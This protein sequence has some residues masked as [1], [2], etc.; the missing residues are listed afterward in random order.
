MDRSRTIFVAKCAAVLGVIPVLAWAYSTGPLPHNTGAPGDTT[1]SQSG[2]HAFTNKS[3]VNTAGGSVQFTFSS[4]TTYTPGTNVHVTV[5][6]TDSTRV[7]GF[8][9]SARIAGSNKQAGTFVKPATGVKQFVQCE[10]TNERDRSSTQGVCPA[11]AP[12]EFIQHSTP[13]TVGKFE[14]D[15]TPPAASIGSVML[16]VAANAANGNGDADAGD[17]IYTTSAT[18]TPATTTGP[19]PTI[20]AGGIAD[21]FN[22]T[23]GVAPETWISIYGTNLASATKTWDGDPAFA[24]GHLPT[25]VSGVSVTVNGKAAPVYFVSSGQINI[26]SP[27]DSATGTVAV[28]VTNANGVSD[29][30]MVTKSNALPAFYAPFN[31]NGKLYVT[32]VNPVSNPAEYWGKVGLDPRVSRPVK[33]GETIELF[34]TGWGSSTNSSIT[35]DM[36]TFTAAPLV[37]QPTITIGG[38][39]AQLSGGAGYLVSPGLYQFNVIV[40]NVPDGDQP[41]SATLGSVTTA[42]N[43]VI[44]VQH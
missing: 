43:V 27:T 32:G 26:L 10:D 22:N 2:C 19:K 33:P 11:S 29:P 3:N 8:E 38:Q 35:T 15:W 16:Y 12:L 40:P 24:Q 23:T 34:G 13:S 28:V 9:A 7:Y 31:Q 5:T 1:C 39:P 36:V 20:S 6:I 4:G 14:F 41:I 42:N 25:S 30:F 17:H 44:T 18:L 21:A 37:T